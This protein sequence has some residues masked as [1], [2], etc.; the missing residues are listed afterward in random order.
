M[1]ENTFQSLL[2]RTNHIRFVC[3]L[4]RIEAYA[5]SS[6]FVRVVRQSARRKCHRLRSSIARLSNSMM[7]VNDSK[8][9][10]SFHSNAV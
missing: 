1:N 4:W 6:L 10:Y 5:L 7:G 9:R 3:L 2:R 8:S